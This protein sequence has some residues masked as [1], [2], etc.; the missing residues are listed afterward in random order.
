[1]DGGGDGAEDGVL[2]PIPLRGRLRLLVGLRPVHARGA[3]RD[4]SPAVQVRGGVL[5]GPLPP[6]RCGG[7]RPV[8]PDGLDG[9]GD[10]GFDGGGDRGFDDFDVNCKDELLVP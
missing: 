2:A 6:G 3:L 4:L 1:D 5:R 10:R 8:R 7:R 9:G